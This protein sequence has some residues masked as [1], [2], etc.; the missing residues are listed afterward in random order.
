MKMQRFVM[1]LSLMAL[2]GLGLVLSQ[3]QGW[4]AE[5]ATLK[6]DQ[7][8][9]TDAVPQV[10]NDPNVNA[11]VTR[12]YWSYT[13][14]G[15]E[16]VSD[17]LQLFTIPSGARIL[18]GYVST[19]DLGDP[20]MSFGYPGSLGRYGFY[21]NGATTGAFNI[22][23]NATTNF[24]DVLTQTKTIQIEFGVG[25]FLTSQTIKGYFEYLVP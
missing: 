7:Q 16:A 5:A 3:E 4:L 13:T 15:T 25:T 6:S 20:V 23:S 2:L 21:Q 19:A 11:K 18:G 22:A 17:V 14:L 9:N 12:K 8:T 24:G 10:M 1:A